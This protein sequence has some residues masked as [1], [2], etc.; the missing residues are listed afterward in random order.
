M[1]EIDMKT[2][3]GIYENRCYVRSEKA[4]TLE[5][6]VKF[7]RLNPGQYIYLCEVKAD[8]DGREV[9]TNI[10]SFWVGDCT[11]YHK[12]SKNDGGFGWNYSDPMMKKIVLEVHIYK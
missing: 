4:M 6:Y 3:T 8:D 12:P 10:E 5:E 7:G 2:T 11:P 9:H 1:M